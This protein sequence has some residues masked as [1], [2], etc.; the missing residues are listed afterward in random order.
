ML[1]K[2]FMKSVGTYGSHFKVGGFAG[3]LCELLIIYY[4]SFEK[5]LESASNE[6]RPGYNIDLMGYG[7]SSLF[8]EPLIVVD[9]VDKNRNVAAA[10]SLQKMSEFVAAS[11]NFLKDPSISYFH[12]KNISYDLNSIKEE[13]KEE[14]PKL[15]Y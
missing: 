7:T 13:F 14:V 11:R 2:R 3:Y 5:V 8:N 15:Y 6:W 9:P 12:P 1:L 10:V 4:S